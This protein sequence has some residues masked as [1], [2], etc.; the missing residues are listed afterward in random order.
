MRLSYSRRSEY[1]HIL[2]MGDEIAGLY[3]PYQPLIRRGLKREI[4]PLD[5]PDTREVG[6]L[7]SHPDPLTLLGV[8]LAPQ[9]RIEELQVS[10]LR[11][12]RLGQSR[13]QG[14][15]QV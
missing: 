12:G 1:Q 15:T 2:T 13:G 6:D 7:H 4:N 14:L 11:L 10:P 9:D 5:G 8:H 3:L